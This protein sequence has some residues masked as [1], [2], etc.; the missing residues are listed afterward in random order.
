MQALKVIIPGDYWDAQIYRG[1]LHLWTM[2][3]G[4]TTIHWDCLIDQLAERAVSTLAVRLGLAQG[5]ALYGKATHPLRAEPEFR[6]WLLPRFQSQ[7]SQPMTVSP[8]Q[9]TTST[10]DQQ[11]NP[12]SDLPTDTEVYR[13]ML[14][15]ATNVGIWEASVGR[16]KH[17]IST[18]P[19][20]LA[21]LPAVSLRAYSRQLALAATG[22]GLFQLGID[23]Y[24]E[25]MYGL[26][27][28]SERHCEKVDWAFRSIF[29]TS[30]LGGGY[31]FSRYWQTICRD[32]T[33][34]N[35][36]DAVEDHILI[37][38][39]IFDDN[40]IDGS[41]S[42]P[43]VSWARSDR[44][45]TAQMHRLTSSSYVQKHVPGGID[46]ASASLGEIVL[47]NEGGHPVS[48]GSATFGAIVE[49]DDRLIVVLSDESQVT[50]HGPITRWRTFPRSVNY[51]NHLHIIFDDHIAIY[52][53]YSDYFVDQRKK[54]FGIEYR[55]D[56]P[57]H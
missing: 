6:D 36:D 11:T 54:R 37:D 18:R 16:T 50:I 35:G 53:F 20:K 1:R 29:A 33:D 17:P 30:T 48:G 21:D 10:L 55:E 44:I 25:T 32:I 49:F 9:L 51:E 41:L 31:L 47:D 46:K 8:C 39:G 22:D 40:M 19:R 14:Y 28:L 12:I 23:E 7:A 26:N 24:E 5:A 43:D 42:Q 38:G 2:S 57:R 4:I 13:R 15:A 45:H 27:N 52:A 3:G 56:V 34:I